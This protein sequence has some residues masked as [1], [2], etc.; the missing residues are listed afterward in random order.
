MMRKLGTVSVA[1]A[2]GFLMMYISMPGTAYAH[3]GH[4]PHLCINGPFQGFDDYHVSKRPFCSV[5]VVKKRD[6]SRPIELP[7]R[8]VSL[9]QKFSWVL[10]SRRFFFV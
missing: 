9:E 6:L 8:R 5:K 10:H 3:A 4:R 2:L 7:D 1:I